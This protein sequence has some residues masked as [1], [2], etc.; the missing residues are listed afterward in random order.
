M[1]KIKNKYSSVERLRTIP[2]KTLGVI[3]M[4]L[5]FMMGLSACRTTQA[6]SGYDKSK[7][8]GKNLHPD[9]K[10]SMAN[11]QSIPS[12]KVKE[13]DKQAMVQKVLKLQMPFIANQG[14]VSKEVSFYAKTFGGSA[15]VTQKGEIVYSF[16][17]IQHQRHIAQSYQKIK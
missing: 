10:S 8:L 17:Q 3:A 15:Y 16:Y 7:A 5:I 11:V 1:D 6:M 4:C 12:D 13:A 14:Q 2:L 9:K